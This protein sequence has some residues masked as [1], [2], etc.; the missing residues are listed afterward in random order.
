MQSEAQFGETVKKFRLAHRLSQL[1][2]AELLADKGFAMHQTT[3]AKLEKGT[4]PIRLAEAFALA[5]ILLMPVWT[6]ER[7]PECSNSRSRPSQP[8]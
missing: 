5:D 4:R 7:K 3:V 8:L 1:Q 2:L 6:P